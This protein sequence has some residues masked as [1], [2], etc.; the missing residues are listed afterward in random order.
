[1]AGPKKRARRSRR[2][3]VAAGVLA[4]LLAGVAIYFTIG[5]WWPGPC[6]V[7]FSGTA[8]N[9]TASGWG[10]GAECQVL[11]GGFLPGTDQHFSQSVSPFGDIVCVGQVPVYLG[12]MIGM[13]V[14]APTWLQWPLLWHEAQAVDEPGYWGLGDWKIGVAVTVR[15]TGFHTL[16]NEAC[17]GFGQP[18]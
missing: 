12:P 11:A 17:S 2:R 15:D 16:G 6:T 4:A 13:S 9:V 7:G 3:V 1:M 14:K 10:S 18:G 8:V 5:G